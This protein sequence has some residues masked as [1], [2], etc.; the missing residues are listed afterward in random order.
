M[1]FKELGHD[2]VTEQQTYTSTHK[3]NKVCSLAN[4]VPIF[5]SWFLTLHYNYIRCHHWEVGRAHKTIL[6]LQL[7]VNLQLF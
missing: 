7:S 3:M 2:L 1:G 4:I 6:F 5:I